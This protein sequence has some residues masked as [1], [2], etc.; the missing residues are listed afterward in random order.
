MPTYGDYF[1]IA[2]TCPD[3]TKKDNIEDCTT[4]GCE[5]FCIA[6]GALPGRNSDYEINNCIVGNVSYSVYVRICSR[7]LCTCMGTL[8][9]S[10]APSVSPS[11]MP[12]PSPTEFPTI[13][14]TSFPT[15]CILTEVWTESRAAELCHDEAH[16]A[17]GVQ[18][19]G[20]YDNP[21]YRRRLEFA[22]ANQLW[23]S[24]D[25]FCLYD[26]DSYNTEQPHAF[27]WNGRCYYVDAGGWCIHGDTD[28]IEKAHAFAANLCEITE[29]CVER[30][31]WT[32]E[33]AEMNCPD[34]YKKGDKGWGTAKVCDKLVLSNDSLYE[35][36]DALY[37]ASFNH[38]LANHMFMSC[39]SECLYDIEN[40][41]VAYEWK[42]E[43]WEMQTFGACFT[44][45]VR[46]YEWASNYLSER[47]C[48]NTP[49]PCL[50]REQEWTKEIA[51]RSCSADAMGKTNKGVD[52][53]VCPDQEEYQN[54]LN[55]SLANRAFLTCDAL[56]VYDVWKEGYEAFRWKNN[57]KCW[58]LTLKGLCIEGNSHD[59]EQMTDYIQN[60]L[61]ETVA[62]QSPTLLPT[63]CTPYH[64]WNEDRAEE[65]CPLAHDDFDTNKRYG[66]EVCDDARSLTKQ[67]S[68]EKSLA[69][70][71]FVTC[72]SLC[73]YDY[74]T[75]IRNIQNDSAD[76]G[77]Y[78]WKH[79]CWKWVTAWTCFTSSL[80][81]F[82]AVSSRA[83]EQCEV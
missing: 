38:S 33:V 26:Y 77:G 80:W 47:I 36:A 1:A 45:H 29:P 76:Y 82:Q 3:L 23:A 28:E 16:H 5:R 65:I 46:E 66:V 55:Y 8:A 22:L 40:E 4:A 43:C 61:C 78:I 21:D 67:I 12:S 70:N 81:E 62:S 64:R 39:S 50:E 17:Y 79:T 48:P 72:S 30:I 73:V 37:E 59:R 18:L 10:A 57:Q 2:E 56:C 32:Q 31:E 11:T 49:S 6:T 27:V 69:N 44:V 24:C 71:F 34:G 68:L 75:I 42:E 53:T 13:T 9:P 20:T 74:D 52:A 14:P 63:D 60:T 15:V 25:L 83:L 41:G 54:R 51:E 7:S 58:K 35:K 19:C